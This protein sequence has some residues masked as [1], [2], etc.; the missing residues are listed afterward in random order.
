M[1][2]LA[3]TQTEQTN[4]GALSYSGNP[5]FRGYVAANQP[6]LLGLV[7]NAPTSGSA[8]NVGN[9]INPTA[10]VN[11]S[12]QNNVSAN[13]V[14]AS[15]NN[16]Y[17]NYSTLSKSGVAGSTTGTGGTGGSGSGSSSSSLNQPLYTQGI[18]QE[19]GATIGNAPTA[20]NILTQQ[21]G[22]AEQ[23]YNDSAQTAIANANQQNAGNQAFLQNQEDTTKAG[24]NLSLTEL[25][26]QIRAQHQG[27]QAQLGST[28]A[29]SS[30]AAELGDEGLAQEQNTSRANIQQQAGGN[31]SS[32]ETQKAGQNAD[33]STIVQGYQKTAADQVATVKANYAQLMNQ[34]ATSLQQ[35]Q[36]EEKARLA[37]FG[38]NLTDAANQALGNIETQ[39]SQN[40]NSLLTQGA[41]VLNATALPTPTAVNPVN[42]PQVSPFSP[43]S[44]TGNA[45]TSANGTPAGGSIYSLL[46]QQSQ[47]PV[48]A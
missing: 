6:G 23:Q 19:Y 3:P 43:G 36:G 41:S 5:D 31:I 25:A 37:E 9:G 48:T 16:L 44:S 13:D 1:A 38:Q 26:S 28:G 20:Q 17:N 33:T 27:L 40:T 47:Q 11:Y 10:L 24:Q 14:V 15:I 21:E 18:Q 30:S 35:A 4:Q 8:F 45:T 34:L 7:G 32:L 22:T 39:L 2:A 12:K 42:A 29:G 46:Q